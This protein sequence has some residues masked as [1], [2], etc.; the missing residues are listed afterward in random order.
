MRAISHIVSGPNGASVSSAT[1][2]VQTRT[3]APGNSKGAGFAS[4]LEFPTFLS[5][6]PTWHTAGLDILNTKPMTTA[7]FTIA[8]VANAIF[9]IVQAVLLVAL[10]NGAAKQ[11]EIIYQSF[12]MPKT[13]LGFFF[14]ANYKLWWGALAVCLVIAAAGV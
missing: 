11:F 9:L 14:L 5:S 3:I 8:C 10:A 12:G 4:E 7:R 2:N 6:T 1:V 13:S